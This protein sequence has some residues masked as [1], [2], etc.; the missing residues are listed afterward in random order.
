MSAIKKDK[1]GQWLE[2][3]GL[4]KSATLYKVVEEAS[5]QRPGGG[6]IVGHMDIESTSIPGRQT[7]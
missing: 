1:A 2:I 7:H 5:E 4:G 6:E 3:D